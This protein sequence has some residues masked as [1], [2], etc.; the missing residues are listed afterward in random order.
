LPVICRCLS[1]LEGFDDDHGAAASGARMVGQVRLVGVLGRLFA[2]RHGEQ[3][4]GLGEAG[5]AIAVGEEAVVA[6]AME[7]LGEHVH[8]ETADELVSVC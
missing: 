1:R 7:A 3:L 5:G 2:A 4:A 8:Q 6:D